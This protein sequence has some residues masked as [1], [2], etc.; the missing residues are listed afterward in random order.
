MFSALKFRVSNPVIKKSCDQNFAGNFDSCRLLD[1]RLPHRRFAS[2]SLQ[3]HN[4]SSEPSI[5]SHFTA[6][7]GYSPSSLQLSQWNLTHRHIL[8]LNVIA[9][10]A[11]VSATWLFCYAIPTLLAFK[12]AAESLEKQM[13]VTRE[14]L[15]DTMA[16]VRLCGMEINNLTTELNDLGQEITQGV[17]SSTQAVR[18]AEERLRWLTNMAPSALAQDIATVKMVT[19]GPVL[20]RTT[21]AIR[22]GIV[23]G[24]AF[25]QI[26]FTLTRFSRMALNFFTS[27][28]KR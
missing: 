17:R 4:S 1:L 3:S 10:A 22:E 18:L 19:P 9:F 25:L 15:P 27:Q 13:D 5:S 12:R 20:A 7:V 24:R 28:A 26:F 6:T 11:A 16:A 21:R 14:E 23:K 8:M 2:L